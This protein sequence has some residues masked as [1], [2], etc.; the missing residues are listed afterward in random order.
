MV[1]RCCEEKRLWQSAHAY[2]LSASVR[3]GS[4]SSAERTE[5]WN[6]SS[7]DPESS[8]RGVDDALDEVREKHDLVGV[9]SEGEEAE[10]TEEREGAGDTDVTDRADANTEEGGGQR[11]CADGGEGGGDGG[12][13][14]GHSGG[15]A[16]GPPSEVG[17]ELRVEGDEMV[18][19]VVR[20]VRGVGWGWRGAQAE[21]REWVMV[22]QLRVEVV[23]L[24]ASLIPIPP[25]TS[26]MV[27]QHR[28]LH[29]PPVH[30]LRRQHQ[31]HRWVG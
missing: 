27:Q 19:V 16:H 5:E 6:D 23:E 1:R 15:Q 26:L 30:P 11:H 13:H 28:V 31:P 18:L 20:G 3:C 24:G 17:A 21:A 14:R 8:V 25:P 7:M 29:H 9:A 10:E 2:G 4:L 12:G 22:V